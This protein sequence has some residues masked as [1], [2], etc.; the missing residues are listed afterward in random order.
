MA[1]VHDENRRIS[2]LVA[3]KDL[4]PSP[5]EEEHNE[6]EE[7]PLPPHACAARRRAD[8]L[9]ARERGPRAR[10]VDRPAHRRAAICRAADAR[11][12]GVRRYGRRA[13]HHDRARAVR[14]ESPPFPLP[15]SVPACARRFLVAARNR[16]LTMTTTIL[17]I[18]TPGRVSVA[19]RKLRS[20]DA[21]PLLSLAS[22]RHRA[23]ADPPTTRRYA[24]DFGPLPETRVHSAQ[25]V[26]KAN[27]HL[28]FGR[29]VAAGLVD[30][31][32][33]VGRYLPQIGSGCVA[34]AAAFFWARRRP[35]RSPGV[36]ER[37]SRDPHG[38]A[39]AGLLSQSGLRA[40]PRLGHYFD[41]IREGGARSERDHPS[42][43][44][45]IRASDRDLASRPSSRRLGGSRG[46]S[47]SARAAQATATHL[48][49][50]C[51]TWT[52]ISTRSPK[53][54]TTGRWRML[55]LSL[56]PFLPFSL[57]PSLPS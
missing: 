24:A 10:Q 52:S 48:C 29:L 8:A 55:P 31:S 21:R 40:P 43:R 37:A 18:I 35:S 50:A 53:A 27:V 11:V 15:P 42:R 6:S 56:S 54:T 23:N 17:Q 5:T 38:S 33:P 39:C 47:T 44:L 13:W 2:P 32:H 1:P 30:L 9:T 28:I 41:R 19:P 34:A 46:A 7:E 16:D 36:P 25:S 14:E 12:A 45:S 20:S 49:R 57:S 22:R 4:V 51:S 3:C 26:G